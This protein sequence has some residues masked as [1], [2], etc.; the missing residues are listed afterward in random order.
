[1]K[2]SIALLEPFA[3]ALTKIGS[4]LAASNSFTIALAVESPSFAVG[5]VGGREVNEDVREEPEIEN[6]EET[7]S[8]RRFVDRVR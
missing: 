5:A 3:T 8:D 6:A 1:M 2:F 4:N 7:D